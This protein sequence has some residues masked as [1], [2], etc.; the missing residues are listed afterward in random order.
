MIAQKG[1]GKIPRVLIGYARVS[2]E[3]QSLDLRRDALSAEWFETAALA[4]AAGHKLMRR[5]ER[6]GYRAV[7]P[8]T[9]LAEVFAR[10]GQPGL[11]GQA[12]A[13]AGGAMDS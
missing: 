7:Q 1:G 5:E 3:D 4:E 2:T 10:I 12:A 9:P 11:I 8:L 6:R 13:S